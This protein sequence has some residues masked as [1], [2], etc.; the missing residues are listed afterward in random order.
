MNAKSMA[1]ALG[2]VLMLAASCAVLAGPNEGL[3]T[4]DAPVGGLANNQSTALCTVAINSNGT[5][6]GG[7]QHV[8]SAQKD[9]AFVG[10]YQI[11][12]KGA[13][14]GNVQASK[15]WARSVQPDTF[16]TGVVPVGSSCTTADLAGNPAG[17]YV[18]CANATGTPSLTS[19]FLT[20]SR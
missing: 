15:G 16:T 2:G 9:P 13:C 19:F 12:M 17:I 6:A 1:P 7:S 4:Q 18:Y 3:A 11:V 20:V 14:G 8:L 10:G 5:I